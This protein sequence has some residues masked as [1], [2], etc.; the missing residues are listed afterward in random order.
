MTL[1][2][3]FSLSH[4]HC[5]FRANQVISFVYTYNYSNYLIFL[6]FHIV[7]LYRLTLPLRKDD[8]QV[9][10][11]FRITKTAIVGLPLWVGGAEGK[12]GA[13]SGG[14]TFLPSCTSEGWQPGFSPDVYSPFLVLG[15]LASSV[16]V[17]AVLGRLWDE[18]WTSLMVL[19]MSPK[20]GSACCY[21]PRHPQSA[22]PGGAW[23]PA[24]SPEGTS[25]P[26]L[27]PLLQRGV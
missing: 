4:P 23:S 1:P 5:P 10:V 20:A 16:P 19:S 22:C 26:L 7:P 18:P 11:S 8:L 24:R 3:P 27:D 21:P 25:G 12:D 17:N 2:A 9:T 13:F 14:G 15:G 6:T